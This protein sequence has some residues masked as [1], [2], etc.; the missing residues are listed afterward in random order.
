MEPVRADV[1]IFRCSYD[2]PVGRHVPVRR[3]AGYAGTQFQM[4]VQVGQIQCGLGLGSIVEI[5]QTQ[6]RGAVGE[7]LLVVEVA[8]RPASGSGAVRSRFRITSSARAL[9]VAR[10]DAAS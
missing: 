5:Q 1:Q 9:R 10:W 8:M 4:N 3:N 2:S 7:D 6:R